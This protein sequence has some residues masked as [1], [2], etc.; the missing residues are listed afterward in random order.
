MGDV[1]I[2]EES[3]KERYKCGEV[4]PTVALKRRYVNCC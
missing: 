3:D 1:N 4:W 2:V